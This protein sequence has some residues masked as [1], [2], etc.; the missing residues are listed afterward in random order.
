MSLS[1]DIKEYAL[2]LGYDRV[3]IT[4]ADKFPIY[5]QQL[6]ERPQMYRWAIEGNA[7]LLK[8]ADPRN[9][10]PDAKSIVVAVYDY[11]KQSYPKEVVGKVG[12]LYL[13]YGAAPPYPIH[14]ARYR[15]LREFLEKQG[16]Q[17]ARGPVGPPARLSAAR[18][19]VAN[20][21][22]NCFAFAEGIGSFIVIVPLVVNAEL[23]YDTPTLEV[24][25]PDKCTL[26]LDACP[27]GSLYEPLRMN[28]L[29]CIAYNSYATPGSFLGVGQEVLPKEI[30]EPMGTW[31][32]GC[33]VCQQ[34]CPRNQPRLKAKLPPNP[35]L[36][37]V[38]NDLRLDK[39]LNMSDE[40]FFNRVLPRLSYIKQKRYVQRNAAVALG[41]LGTEESVAPLAQAMQNPD[42]LVR[43]HAAWALGRIGSGR[44]KQTLEASLSR[45]TS[46]YARE[47]IREAL[48]RE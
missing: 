42:E 29:R 15:L 23:D 34:V 19:G 27:T 35:Y 20:Y 44:A 33:D 12:R 22:K 17:V 38:A 13:A 16:I 41:N 6:T 5:E 1:A 43:G 10:L 21:G 48:A 46:A 24:K 45:E 3:G 32:F 2:S 4:T 8:S 25:C 31:I 18:A 39:L 11:F 7:Q 14:Q 40:Y 26:C 9:I 47:E 36:E 30:R 28:P 37:H